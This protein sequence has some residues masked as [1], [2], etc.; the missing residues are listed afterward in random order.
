VDA[1]AAQVLETPAVEPF[2]LLSDEPIS[3]DHSDPRWVAILPEQAPCVWRGHFALLTGPFVEAADDDHH[4]FRRGQPLEICSK[5]LAV[6]ETDGYR[7]HFAII[8]RAGDAVTGAAASC[9]P[10][11]GCC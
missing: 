8:N 1:R 10:A 5:T 4:V 9:D 6:L 7:G 2:F 11:G 3:L